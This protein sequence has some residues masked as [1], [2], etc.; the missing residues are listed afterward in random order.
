[1][2]QLITLE[3]VYKS[4]RRGEVDIRVL[5]GV[6]LEIQRGELVALVGASG[7]GKSTLMNIL[8]CLDRP[9]SGK[10]WLDG[11]EVSPF[12]ADQRALLRSSKIGFVFQNFNLLPRTN[13][14]EN[15]LMPL[16]YSAN[17]VPQNERLPR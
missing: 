8:G 5:Q 16:N 11:N 13:A 2:K 1:M 9:T 14:L 10:Y 15:V 4:Y 7:S 6:A 12:S 17:Q 3:S